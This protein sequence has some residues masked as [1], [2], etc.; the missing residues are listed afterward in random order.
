MKD[1]SVMG[2]IRIAIIEDTAEDACVTQKCIE[3]YCFSHNIDSEIRVFS[4]A[5]AF[6]DSTLNFDVAFLDIEMPHMSGISLAEEIRRHNDRI[7]MV[8]VTR[9]ARYAV[10]GYRV[11][12]IDYVLKPI[13][14]YDFSLT[15]DKVMAAFERISR[16]TSYT[17]KTR[18]GITTLIASDIYYVESARHHLVFHTALGSVEVYGYLKDAEEELNDERFFRASN[19]YLI[20]LTHVENVKGFD[21]TVGGDVLRLSRTKKGELMDRLTDYY[22]GI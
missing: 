1:R 15:M 5:Y 8:F 22:G 19:C 13:S 6:L 21:V 7:I 11:G 20:N 14:E 18:E 2:N 4:T 3:R 17:I 9:M 16:E 12:V 10:S